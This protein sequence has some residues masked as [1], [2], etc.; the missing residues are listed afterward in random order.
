MFLL[1]GAFGNFPQYLSFPR[2]GGALYG[3]AAAAPTISVQSGDTNEDLLLVSKGSGVVQANGNPVISSVTGIPA[4]TGSPS[5]STYLRGDGTWSTPSGGNSGI[6]A[7]AQGVALGSETFTIVSGSVTQITGTTINGGYAPA[8]DD[9]IL[10]INAPAST[11]VGSAYGTT[12][13]PA[14]GIYTVTGNTTNL[15]LSRSSDMSGSVNPTGLFVWSQSISGWSD[16]TLWYVEN[17][18]VGD[19][20]FTW[21]TTAV[22]FR[23]VFGG[24]GDL[25]SYVINTSLFYVHGN[26][27]GAQL[28]QNSGAAADQSLTLPAPTTDTIVA[29]TSTDT[30]TNKRITKRT[31]T[32]T[33][34]ATPTINTDNYDMYGLTAQT[35]NITSFTTNLSGTPTNGQELWIYIVGTAT[36]TIAWGASFEAS[37]IALPTTTSGTNRLDV[38]FVWNAATSK[39]RCIMVV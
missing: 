20:T 16:Q 34:S 4:V 27:Y 17:P 26:S 37:T 11:G 14:N 6:L 39:W 1:N 28:I 29:R 12:T 8:I 2:G 36:R 18:S 35:V 7:P 32:T 31:G 23:P 22:K 25:T 5:S 24:N 3:T 30:L 10:I 38:K 21:G 9:R 33:S 13:Q 15:S 19:T